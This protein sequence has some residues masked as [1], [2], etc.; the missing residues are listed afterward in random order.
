MPPRQEGICDNCGTE[1]VHRKDD[2]PETI[3]NRLDVYEQQTVPIL[4]YYGGKV[5]I[6]RVDGNQPIDVVSEAV[7]RV[8]Q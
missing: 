6:H 5:D 7:E 3:A 1:L 4:E 2:H 8:V